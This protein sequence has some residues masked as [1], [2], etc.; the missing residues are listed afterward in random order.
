VLHLH[1]IN[2]KVT[3]QLVNWIKYAEKITPGIDLSI[4]GVFFPVYFFEKIRSR[5]GE[6]RSSAGDQRRAS[7]CQRREV[8]LIIN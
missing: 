2:Y 6:R 7:R 1:L 3:L 5:A 8:Y 4:Q